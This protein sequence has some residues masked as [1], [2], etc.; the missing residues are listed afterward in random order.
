MNS[1]LSDP[2]VLGQNLYDTQ[3]GFLVSRGH[4][5]PCNIPT[6]PPTH[7]STGQ[8]C[9]K[10]ANSRPQHVRLGARQG[11]GFLVPWRAI[12]LPAHSHLEPGRHFHSPPHL[13]LVRQARDTVSFFPGWLQWY[14]VGR[15]Q[16][17]RAVEYS[18]WP[19]ASRPL[20]RGPREVAAQSPKGSQP[21]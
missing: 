13:C 12:T 16:P 9:T 20:P 3:K 19:P 5:L 18:G 8:D 15:P 4:L 10:P 6:D 14:R 7:P 11:L 1:D 2:V 21:L 17:L